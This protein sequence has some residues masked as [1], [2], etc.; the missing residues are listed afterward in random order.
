MYLARVRL[1]NWRSYD[2][3]QFDFT[4]PRAGKPIVLVG[5]MNGH[6][7]TSFL[8]ALYLGIFGRYGLRYCEG[9]RSALGGGEE[10]PHY[11]RALEMYRRD[12]AEG[13]E[14]T[15]IEVVLSPIYLTMIW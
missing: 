10:I 13:D 8:L 2:A 9:F 4:K 1:Q 3:A 12:V 7:K 6:G 14:P 11:R 15:E 5:A